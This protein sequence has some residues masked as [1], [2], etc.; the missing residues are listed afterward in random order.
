MSKSVQPERK[1]SVFYRP[2]D[3]ARYQYTG[4]LTDIYTGEVTE[5]VDRT[6]QHF[7]AECDVNTIVKGFSKRDWA[8]RMLHAKDE[9]LYQDLPAEFDYQAAM[10]TMIQADQAFSALPAHVRERFKNSPALFLQFFQ[11]PNNQEELVE[12]G[13]VD[14]RVEPPPQRVEVVNQVAPQDGVQGAAPPAEG[15]APK[16]P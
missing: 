11:D 7:K 9:G 12:L 1:R 15:K 16:G 10:N 6:Q 5:A 8:E 4:R 13:L 14:R 3:R 2:R